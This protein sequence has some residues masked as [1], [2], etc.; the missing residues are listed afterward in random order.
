MSCPHWNYMKKKLPLL[1]KQI[2]SFFRYLH[3]TSWDL[4]SISKQEDQ[5]AAEGWGVEVMVGEEKMENE[6]IENKKVAEQ[7]KSSEF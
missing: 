7:E 3:R 1:I 6:L 4:L 2:V 5:K